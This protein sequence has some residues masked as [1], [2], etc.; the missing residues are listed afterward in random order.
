VLVAALE[1]VHWPRHPL[2]DRQVPVDA[3]FAE[4]EEF[5]ALQYAFVI[6]DVLARITS[7]LFSAMVVLGLLTGAHLFYLFQGRAS[8][9]TVDLAAVIVI[10]VVAIKIVVAMERDVIISTLRRT[11]PGRIDFTWDFVRQVATYGLLP[12]IAI[13]ASLFPEVGG[14]LFGWVEP[15]RK[16]VAP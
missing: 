2:S 3:W 9:L 11:T 16:L 12:L 7:S 14:S 1:R 5:V 4:C 15:L 10:G 13:I 8:L 6:R